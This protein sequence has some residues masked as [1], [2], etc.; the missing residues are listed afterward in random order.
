MEKEEEPKRKIIL[1]KYEK[2]KNKKIKKNRFLNFGDVF[3]D[4]DIYMYTRTCELI[5]S[6]TSHLL[7][8]PKKNKLWRH[9]NHYF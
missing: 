5:L 7:L 2:K 4:S 8:P 1:Y 3:I 9:L 6:L